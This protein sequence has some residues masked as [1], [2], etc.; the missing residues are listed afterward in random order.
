MKR[1]PIRELSEAVANQIAAGEVVERPAS[2]VKELVENAIDADARRIEIEIESG[3]LNGIMVRDDGA[4]IPADEAALAFS[5]HA[6]S[7]LREADELAAVSSLG[8]RG[9]ALPSIASVSRVE[10]RTRTAESD[11]GVRIRIEG[12]GPLRVEPAGAPVGT[13]VAVRD[14][15]YNT[16]A[17]RKFLRSAASERRAVAYCV[18]HLALAHPG[19][20]FSLKS[21]GSQLL[22]TPGDGRLRSV[23]AA[24]YGYEVAARCLDVNWN[25]NAPGDASESAIGIEIRGCIGHPGDVSG[26]RDRQS[27]F[28]NGRWIGSRMLSAAAEKGYESLLSPRRFPLVALELRLPPERVD[29]NVHPAKSEVRFRD[30]REVFGAVLRAVR[31]ALLSENLVSAEPLAGAETSVPWITRK[32]RPDEADPARGLIVWRTAPHEE[33]AAASDAGL[34]AQ[35]A[36]PAAQT[37]RL[38]EPGEHYSPAACTGERLHAADDSAGG[39]PH[40]DHARLPL[41]GAAAAAPESAEEFRRWLVQARLLG[42]VFGT[43]W[44]LEA[45]GALWIAD[46]HVV[47]ERILYE[48]YLRRF[49]ADSGG[50]GRLDEEQKIPIQALL[51]P[52]TV[53]LTPEQA[54]AAD[55]I[56]ARL[57]ELGF[58]AEPFGGRSLLVREVPA[59][60]WGELPRIES[61]IE[62]L[63]S[64]RSEPGEE[65]RHRL[66]AAAACRA[67]VKAGSSLTAEQMQAMLRDLAEASNPFACPHGRPILVEISREELERR[68]KRR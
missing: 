29:V 17:R 66:A 18:T 49:T 68:F 15:F 63:L 10:M 59:G 43:Y 27:F 41:A 47:H 3:G 40:A 52:Q 28:V 64:F 51:A 44:L 53:D 55:E 57:G 16:P 26:N 65:R 1:R 20:A 24:V 42:R 33:T 32:Q 13:E 4:G 39:D 9:E 7:K 19:V 14:L 35:T 21:D 61:L 36:L 8:F 23:L 38:S 46:Q 6:T 62:D 56:I 37:R 34:R 50:G 67:A 58:R 54:A 22:S 30:E 11:A 60:L 5:R 2:V 12:G 48:R 31:A 25:S 45:P